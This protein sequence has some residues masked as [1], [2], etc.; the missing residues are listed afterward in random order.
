MGG[1]GTRGS[2]SAASRSRRRSTCSRASEVDFVGPLV[3]RAGRAGRP[4][5]RRRGASSARP[6]PPPGTGPGARDVPEGR[7]GRSRGAGRIA[8][9]HWVQLHGYQTPGFVRAVKGIAPDVRVIKVLHVRGDECIEEPLI[10][11]VREGGRGRLPLRRGGEDGRVGST[12]QTLD[13]EVVASLADRLTR[14]FLLAGGISAENRERVRRRSRRTPLPRD[15][16]R[17]ERARRRRQGQ[18]GEGRGDLRAPGRAA[19]GGR[20]MPSR[21]ID[22]LLAAPPAGDHGGQAPGPP[23]ASS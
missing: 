10:G 4:A 15:R 8:R 9:V 5:A 22:A 7:R 11:V 17:H 6:P 16:R 13:A 20:A 2:R 14:P 3:R 1:N 23:T 12:G 19:P 18:R 21:F